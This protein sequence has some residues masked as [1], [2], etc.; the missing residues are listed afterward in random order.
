MLQGERL[1]KR[2][3]SFDTNILD[4]WPGRI[5]T[6]DRHPHVELTESA[7]LLVTEL[8]IE[9]T[10]D[11]AWSMSAKALF[12]DAPYFPPQQTPKPRVEGVQSATVVC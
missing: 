2:S 10:P 1:G 9:G 7:K 12:T 6:F 5:V 11:E 4:L 8:S 3:T